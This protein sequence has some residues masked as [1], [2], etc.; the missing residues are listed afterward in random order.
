MFFNNFKCHSHK[1]N[2]LV[3]SSVQKKSDHFYGPAC[4]HT[5]THISTHTYTKTIKSKGC[6]QPMYAL[7]PYV[8]YICADKNPSFSLVHWQIDF[9]QSNKMVQRPHS[10][11][12]CTPLLHHARI[13]HSLLN[14][15]PRLLAVKSN[16]CVI[17]R[18]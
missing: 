18:H 3:L 2:K 6:S 15:F 4:A 9:I 17:S 12:Y 8:R 5:H 16:A 7:V 11:F 10:F 13:A 1:S 14:N